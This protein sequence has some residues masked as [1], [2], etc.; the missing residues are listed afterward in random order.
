MNGWMMD[1]Q[2]DGWVGDIRMGEM[3]RRKKGVR[4]EREEIDGG[5][6]G[7]EVVGHSTALKSRVMLCTCT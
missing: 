2:I 5:E 4:A 1:G 7:R 3:Q 6:R